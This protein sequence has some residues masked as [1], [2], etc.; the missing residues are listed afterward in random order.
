MRV[1]ITTLLLFT[2]MRIGVGICGCGDDDYEDEGS[3]CDDIAEMGKPM[4]SLLQP[5]SN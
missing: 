2:C 3:I 5:T 4:L 1:P